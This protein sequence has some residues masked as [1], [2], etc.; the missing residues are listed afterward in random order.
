MSPEWKEAMDWC[1]SQPPTI[2]QAIRNIAVQNLINDGFE[3]VGT[4]DVNCEAYNLYQDYK[5]SGIPDVITFLLQAHVSN[6]DILNAI[7]ERKELLPLLIGIHEKLDKRIETILKE[8][9]SQND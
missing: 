8:G 5:A 9:D 3:E 6:G 1:R 4:S 7:L 2:Q